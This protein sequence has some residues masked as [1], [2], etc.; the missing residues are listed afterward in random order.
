[1]IPLLLVNSKIVSDF[2]KKANIFNDFF[3]AQCTLKIIKNLN[4]NKAHGHDD[5][6]IRMLKVCDSEAVEP[7]SLIYKNCINSGIF[8]DIWERCHIIPTY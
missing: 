5:I 4:V 7:L 8:P 3:A 1:M 2:T 6:S